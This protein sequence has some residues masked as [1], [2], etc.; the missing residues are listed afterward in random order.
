MHRGNMDHT[1]QIAK[2][3]KF[4]FVTTHY[5]FQLQSLTNSDNW[6]RCETLKSCSQCKWLTQ[7]QGYRYRRD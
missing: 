4:C 6:A 7:G 5:L 2:R 3:E 1:W